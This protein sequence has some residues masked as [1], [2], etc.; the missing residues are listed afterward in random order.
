MST[1]TQ[2][3]IIQNKLGLHTRTT[4]KNIRFKLSIRG[5][6]SSTYNEH[7]HTNYYYPKYIKLAYTNYKQKYQI[8]IEHKGLQEQHS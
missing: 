2:N 5:Y 7:H 1:I 8:Q 4:N 6:R 3:I